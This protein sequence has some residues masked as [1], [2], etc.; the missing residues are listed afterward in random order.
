M[1]CWIR[2]ATLTALASLSITASAPAVAQ[3]APAATPA[4]PNKPT[5][6]APANAAAPAATSAAPANATAPAA[7]PAQPA[8]APS[9]KQDGRA[10]AGASTGPAP[11]AGS[12]GAAADAG[13]PDAAGALPPGHPEVAQELP[14]GHPPVGG[15]AQ[16]RARA[17]AREALGLFQ[18]PRDTVQDDAT[19]PPGVIV[20]TVRDPDGNPVPGV[21][22][23]I[24]ILHSSVAKGD[25]SNHMRKETDGSGDVRLENLTIGAGTRYTA[26]VARDGAKFSLPP[27]ALGGETGVRGVLHIYDVSRNVND[28]LVGAQGIVY[29]QLRQEAIQ[30]QQLFQVYNLGRTAWLP[31]ETFALPQ[32]Y[33]AF[34]KPDAM[35]GEMRFDEV[36]GTGAALRGTV[37]PGRHEAS[38]SFQIPLE[39]EERQTFRIALPPR[40][41]EVRVIAEASKSMTLDVAGFPKAQ[42]TQNPRDGKRILITEKES[43]RAEGGLKYVE[44]TLGGLPTPGPGRW[45]ALGLA[46]AAVLGAVVNVFRRRDEDDRQIDDDRRQELIE[47]REALLDEFVELERARK[48]GDIGPK[49]YERIRTALL[50]ALARLVT[51]IES[52]PAPQESSSGPSRDP[53]G[54]A[55]KASSAT[56]SRP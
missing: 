33:K 55:R 51:M 5:S 24:D 11:A 19:L 49:T 41:A 29:I 40:M 12:S 32:G 37:S 43:T 25:S 20:I 45:I 48:R 7:T 36:K 44:I 2:C 4:A 21:P 18:A 56:A 52:A 1:R 6:A 28:V 3:P 15:D 46:A 14:A 31:D 39:Q 27:I 23:D 30:V 50:D 16:E 9:A 13:A 34:R 22:V 8:A 38:Y 47:A 17:Q 53:A 35:M 26:S 10:P 42:R 54:S